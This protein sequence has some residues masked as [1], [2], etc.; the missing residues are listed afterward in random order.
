MRQ[1]EISPV[2]LPSRIS[3]LIFCIS[4][5]FLLLVA[6]VELQ[7][8]LD[9]FNS[10]VLKAIREADGDQAFGSEWLA[11]QWPAQYGQ[12]VVPG[13]W[14]LLLGTAVALWMTF[15]YHPANSLS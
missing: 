2:V 15:P 11:V 6:S 1:R 10:C 5:L 9:L 8:G 14:T 3:Q 12:L 7:I 13:S 4:S